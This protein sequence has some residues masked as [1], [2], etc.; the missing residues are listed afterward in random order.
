M[1]KVQA[2]S[3]N[4]T[5]EIKEMVREVHRQVHGVKGRECHAALLNNQCNVDAAVKQ[6][7]LDQLVRLG[8]K[9]RDSCQALLER[10][11]W[12]LEQAASALMDELTNGSS[13]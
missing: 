12:N 4:I 9:R 10:H 3:G 11:K 8:M 7:K 1:T 2:S 13:V 6:L 5:P